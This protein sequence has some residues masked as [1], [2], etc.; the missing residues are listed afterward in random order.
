[1]LRLRGIDPCRAYLG[2]H[3]N[4]KMYVQYRNS[5]VA[6]AGTVPGYR[7]AQ[8]GLA[9]Q[10]RNFPGPKVRME[11]WGLW[12]LGQWERDS[13]KEGQEGEGEGEEREIMAETVPRLT[14]LPR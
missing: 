10:L 5:S 3:T 2:T 1:M 14:S 12:G 6:G 9:A 11:Y 7:G 4:S 8:V 13:E